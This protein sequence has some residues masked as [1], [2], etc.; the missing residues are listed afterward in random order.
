MMSMKAILYMAITPSGYV[1][2]E[3][4]D[5]SFVSRQSWESFDSLSKKAGNLIIGRRTFE[6]SL[7]DNTFPYPNRFNIVMIH[8][9]VENKW[10]ENVLFTDKSPKEVL[11]IL[12]EK[13][14]ETAFIGG[15]GSINSAFMRERLIDE[16]YLD[17]ESKLFG[18][19][20][21]L[22]SPNDFEFNLELLETKN[23]NAST[24]QL[25]YKVI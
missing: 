2:K 17:V 1:A 23:L 20:I 8:D 11:K 24:I 9:K 3:N 22:F 7:Q 10:G 13:G 6:I 15:G 14:F 19:G 12:E 21:Q 4:D 18:K 5:T 25:H 16:I